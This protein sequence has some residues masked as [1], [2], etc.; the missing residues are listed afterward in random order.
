[1]A[2]YLKT[3]VYKSTVSDLFDIISFNNADAGPRVPSFP[4]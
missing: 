1:M 4:P 2:E 3:Q